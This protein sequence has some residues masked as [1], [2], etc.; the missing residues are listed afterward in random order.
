M[1]PPI[2]Q[3]QRWLFDTAVG[4]CDV[5]LSVSG[6]GSRSTAGLLAKV[7][8]HAGDSLDRGSVELRATIA[9]AYGVDRECVAITHGAQEAMYLLMSSTLAP[10]D[11]VAVHTPGWQQ[12]THLP[13][14]SGPPSGACPPATATAWTWRR[15][16]RPAGCAPGR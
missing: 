5:D 7:A 13:E 15:S 10:G 4:R 12:H 9:A 2:Y 1:R 8:H 3:S 11:S 14:R 16:S 6:I